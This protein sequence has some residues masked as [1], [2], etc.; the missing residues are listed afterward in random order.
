MPYNID[1]VG[2]SLVSAF[3]NLRHEDEG[4]KHSLMCLSMLVDRNYLFGA[5]ISKIS[6]FFFGG[7]S[8]PVFLSIRAYCKLLNLNY[9]YRSIFF[10]TLFVFIYCATD[11]FRSSFYRAFSYNLLTTSAL[12]RGVAEYQPILS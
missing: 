10:S 5:H 8:F 4:N 7:E 3:D 2:K 9:R 12:Y 1:I 6:S 11:P